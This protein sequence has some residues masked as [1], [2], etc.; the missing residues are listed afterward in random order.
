M[1]QCEQSKGFGIIPRNTDHL[2]TDCSQ[3][4]LL[5]TVGAGLFC[6]PAGKGCRVK[7]DDQIIRRFQLL[8]KDPFLTILVSCSEIRHLFT[9]GT[10]LCIG[11]QDYRCH[12][13]ENDYDFFHDL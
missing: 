5:V 7:I 12:Q 8:L 10:L 1:L 4:T 2:R 6:A 11:N 3:F 13:A 9:Q